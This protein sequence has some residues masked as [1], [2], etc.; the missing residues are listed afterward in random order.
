MENNETYEN[1]HDIKQAAWGNEN[2]FDKIK[3]EISAY[4]EVQEKSKVSSKAK[5]LEA[6]KRHFRERNL[7]DPEQK[8]A[9][10]TDE[11]QLEGLAEIN[12]K[13]FYQ[14]LTFYTLF[15]KN[16]KI[17]SS[18]K[19]IISRLIKIVNKYEKEKASR[20]AKESQINLPLDF[21]ETNN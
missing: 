10:P 11:E 17:I 12:T 16:D 20:V 2:T 8:Y 7:Q 5:R 15:N 14:S 18:M 4:S 19:G 3:K 13:E 21:K 9:R 6:I 1:N